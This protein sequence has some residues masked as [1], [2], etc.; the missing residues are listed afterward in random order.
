MN[1]ERGNG[2]GHD[3]RESEELTPE[4]LYPNER[5]EF[6]RILADL[7]RQ[8]DEIRARIE[9]QALDHYLHP[10]LMGRLFGLETHVID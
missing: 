1:D 2:N 9:R 6:A 3:P 4:Q 5:P 7:D 10:G 8:E